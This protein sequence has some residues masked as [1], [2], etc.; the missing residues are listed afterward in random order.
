MQEPQISSMDE[1]G[2]CVFPSVN[3]LGVRIH[4]VSAEDIIGFAAGICGIHGKAIIANVNI[5]AMD[6]ACER[7]WFRN[8]L[9]GCELVFCDGFGVSL[10]SLFLGQGWIRRNTFPDW[11]GELMATAV[12]GNLSIYLLGARPD[13]IEKAAQTF[14]SRYP[15]VRIAGCHHGYFEKSLA[16]PE[17]LQVVEE[18]NHIRPNILVVGFGMPLQEQWLLENW[19]RLDVNVAL[20][21]GAAFDFI[22]GATY[23]AP[24]WITDHG[25]E[26]LSRLVIEPRRLWRRYVLEIPPFFWRVILQM[27]RLRNFK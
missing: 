5:H 4:D 22:A 20:P 9:N 23:R 21:V 2:N 13:V 8:F 7:A 26:W 27:S 11:I 17:N 12:E 15:A 3:V 14:R 6:I 18:I 16:S 1:S 24:R 25:L 19:E 10:A